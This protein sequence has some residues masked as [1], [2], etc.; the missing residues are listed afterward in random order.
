MI[1]LNVK[2]NNVIRSLK[3]EIELIRNADDNTFWKFIENNGGKLQL[4]LIGKFPRLNFQNLIHAR[5]NNLTHLKEMNEIFKTVKVNNLF[6]KSGFTLSPYL[7]EIIKILEPANNIINNNLANNNINHIKNEENYENEDNFED[8]EDEI[9]NVGDFVNSKINFFE[10]D[11]I[12]TEMMEILR[13][14]NKNVDDRDD[15]DE[16]LIII[17]TSCHS[18]YNSISFSKRNFENGGF[19]NS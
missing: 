12:E 14:L 13:D 17:F 8:D 3:E 1:N 16:K 7:D 19:K 15:G 4:C 5:K 6:G 10:E 2:I 9:T 11:S 18:L